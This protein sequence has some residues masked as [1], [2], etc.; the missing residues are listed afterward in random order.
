MNGPCTPN[1]AVVFKRLDDRMVLV[2]LGTNQIFELNDTGAR[3]WEL[4]QEDIVGDDLLARLA[5]EFD[6]DP[7]ILRNEIEALLSEL[8]NEGLVGS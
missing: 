8:V 4:L 5:G 3:V 6:V 2:H 1:S 7:L